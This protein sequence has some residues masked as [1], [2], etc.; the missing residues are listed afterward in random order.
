MQMLEGFK[1]FNRQSYFF[2]IR[3]IV[4]S[5]SL[6]PANHNDSNKKHQNKP[7]IHNIRQKYHIPTSN[8]KVVATSQAYPGPICLQKSAQ[9]S[10]TVK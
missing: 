9:V 7:S 4:N 3:S 8:L 5:G 2:Q 6:G 1:T 10:A